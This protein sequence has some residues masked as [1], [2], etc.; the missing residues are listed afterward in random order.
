MPVSYLIATLV[1]AALLQVARVMVA[2]WLASPGCKVDADKFLRVFNGLRAFDA[3]RLVESW[4][5]KPDPPPD[6]RP[7]LV[8]DE[9]SA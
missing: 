6:S 1:V 2:A 4:R 5:S 8:R 7:R 9:D 3:T